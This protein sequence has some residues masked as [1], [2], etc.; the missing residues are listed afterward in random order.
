MIEPYDI[1]LFCPGYAW[2]I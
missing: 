1:K 2:W